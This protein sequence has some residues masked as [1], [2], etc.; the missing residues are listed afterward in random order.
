MSYIRRKNIK[1]NTYLYEE[2]SY[3][4]EKGIS[5]TRHIA[6]IGPENDGGA[7][8]Q[9]AIEK[10]GTTEN[11]YEAGFIAR[12]GEMINL[13]KE[14]KGEHKDVAVALTGKIGKE[15]RERISKG[16]TGA[17]IGVFLEKTGDQRIF[18]NKNYHDMA[19]Q[20]SKKPSSEQNVRIK[21]LWVEH[22]ARHGDK[23]TM[24]IEGSKTDKQGFL[25][26]KTVNSYEGYRRETENLPE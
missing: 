17:A 15:E 8:E 10:F 4:D 13:H 1:G 20:L 19:V 6:Y 12:N 9:I 24:T 2:E 11:P 14:E 18:I 23:A 5:H 26:G 22:K 7:I 3:R 21:K 16:G 25:S